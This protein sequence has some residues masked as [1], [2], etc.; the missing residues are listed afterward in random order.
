MENRVVICGAGQVGFSIARYLSQYDDVHVTCIDTDYELITHISDSLDI[1]GIHGSATHPEILERAG[2][3]DAH[4]FIAV[5]QVDEVNM[6]ACEIAH[7]LYQIPLKIARIRSKAYLD[8]RWRRIFDQG[9]LSVDIV[10]CPEAEVARALCYGL[11]VPEAFCVC[12][13]FEETVKIIGI[14]CTPNSPVVNTPLMHIPTLFPHIQMTI[15]S[16]IRDDRALIPKEK[17]TLRHGDSVY[18]CCESSQVEKVME[19]FTPS[20]KKLET[21]MILGGGNIGLNLAQSVEEAYP[22]MNIC[23]IETKRERAEEISRHLKNTVILNGEALDSEILKEGG[24]AATEMVIA[25]TADDRVNTLSALLCKR[26]GAKRVQALVN[27]RSYMPLV[28]SLGV[29]IVINPRTITVSRILE[30]IRGQKV[31]KV[32]ALREG[33]GEIMEIQVEKGCPL[34]GMTL[35]DFTES[36]EVIVGALWRGGT[37]LFPTPTLTFQARDHLLCMVPTPMVSKIKKFL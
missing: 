33:M 9:N 14:K 10:I 1:Q 32:H 36:Q 4:V 2:V 5:T 12:P 25:V 27:N 6:V 13:F 28:T 23:I 29:D 37:V 17:E 31:I 30:H 16:I 19:A 3:K 24:I 34:M 21:L 35:E 20:P 18:L 22:K 15:L 7:A 26:H 8:L 11:T